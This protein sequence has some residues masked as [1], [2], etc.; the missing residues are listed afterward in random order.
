MCVL[1]QTLLGVTVPLAIF[2]ARNL[3]P[4]RPVPTFKHGCRSL[5]GSPIFAPH[6]RSF[7]AAGSRIRS[8]SG[9][10]LAGVPKRKNRWCPALPSP[11]A[12][13]GLAHRLACLGPAL[14]AMARRD[15]PVRPSRDKQAG[16]ARGSRDL[17]GPCP[18]SPSW[19]PLLTRNYIWKPTYIY[20]Y[21]CVSVSGRFSAKV[22]PGALPMAPAGKMLRSESTH[23]QLRGPIIM[24]L[25]SCFLVDRQ[26]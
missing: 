6:P 18:V 25:R 20:I 1:A 14:S 9:A 19:A 10:H 11:S 3:F 5:R 17:W 16:L 15:P 2:S 26:N 8:A 7:R 23:N 4:P 24:P 21:I 12:A 13:L 22:G